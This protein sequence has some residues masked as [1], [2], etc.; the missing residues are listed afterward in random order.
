MNIAVWIASGLLAAA[1]L[2]AGGTKLLTPK[3]RLGMQNSARVLRDTID[4]VEMRLASGKPAVA[5]VTP[6]KAEEKKAVVVTTSGGGR[7]IPR[8]AWS[9]K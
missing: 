3:E 6:A 1:Y 7:A 2:F 4:A 8:T 5:K 9:G